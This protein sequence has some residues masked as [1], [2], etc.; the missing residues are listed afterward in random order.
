[1]TCRPNAKQ[2]GC[3]AFGIRGRDAIRKW[4]ASDIFAAKV[5]LDAWET[6]IL[7]R[8]LPKVDGEQ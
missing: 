4:A 1:M 7:S 8:S 6:R 3:L 5:T 2:F